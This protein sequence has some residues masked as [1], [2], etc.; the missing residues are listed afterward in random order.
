MPRLKPSVD[1]RLQD[2]ELFVVAGGF[3]DRALRFPEMLLPPCA[4][5]AGAVVLRF[6][7][8]DA[9]NR[10]DKICSVLLDK[11]CSLSILDYD[12]Y[13][14]YDLDSQIG[15]ILD[16]QG[17]DALCID[18]SGMSRLAMMILADVAKERDIA[19]RVLC[20]E[21]NDYAPTRAEFEEARDSGEQHLPTSFIHTGVYDVLRIPRLSSVRMQNE[22]SALIAFDSFNESL[23]QALVNVINPTRLV[24]INGRPPRDE[25]RWREEATRL[26]HRKL[27]EEWPAEDLLQN[28]GAASAGVLTTS[29]LQYAET[30][31]LLVRLYWRLSSDHR[32]ILAP[33][34]S[35]MQT[36]GAYLL[37]A[38]HDDVHIEYPTVAGFF[39]GRYSSGVHQTWEINF[40]RMGA[41]VRRLRQAELRDHLGLP[42]QPVNIEIG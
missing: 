42:A 5:S 30:Y 11:G 4:G 9:A 7:P 1:F 8:P 37:R 33:T 15:S 39:A 28:D 20:A 21:A 14:P 40:G 34:G 32:I 10:F 2:R 13:S 41:F 35:K 3:E 6:L 24:L 26:V 29:T 22:A 27:R 31:D 36:L 18:T 25:L 38:V 16:R 23:C 19:L 17:A 12:R